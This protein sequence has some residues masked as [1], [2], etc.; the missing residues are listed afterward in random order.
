MERE[1]EKMKTCNGCDRL[2]QQI[3]I[4][5]DGAYYFVDLC[6]FEI[7]DNSF[8][9]T[10]RVISRHEK[11]AETTDWCPKEEDVQDERD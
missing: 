6:V 5:W 3:K 4:I 1:G 10:F 7:S 11:T 8:D 2:I 9:R